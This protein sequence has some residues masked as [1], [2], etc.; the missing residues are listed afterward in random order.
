M[1]RTDDELFSL[2][3]RGDAA[4]FLQIYDRHKGKV[5]RYCFSILG[6]RQQAEDAAQETFLK[7]YAAQHRY[8]DGS[9]VVALLLRIARNTALKDLARRRREPAVLAGMDPR[10]P[11]ADLDPVERA[12]DGRPTPDDCAQ[13][14]ELQE[15][16]AA[17]LGRLPDRLRRV[18]LLHEIEDYSFAEIA[19]IL[20][21][22]YPAVHKRFTRA[23]ER[24]RASLERYLDP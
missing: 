22:S 1:I 7:L 20:Q 23:A 6:D 24:L 13:S 17:A 3:R 19:E 15:H 5:L 11:A 10:R 21:I 9:Q 14:H 12:A 4:A 8:R 18:Y 16:L 2:A